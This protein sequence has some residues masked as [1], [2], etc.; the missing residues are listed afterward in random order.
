MGL[1]SSAGGLKRSM[2]TGAD[3]IGSQAGTVT[4][5]TA[6]T[7][8]I[9]A[10]S[11]TLPSVSA[12]TSTSSGG[13]EYFSAASSINTGSPIE[14][15]LSRR[16][17]PP[18]PLPL[19]LPS[20]V[21]ET[22][23]KLNQLDL[24]EKPLPSLPL[25]PPSLPSPTLQVAAT[26]SQLSAREPALVKRSPPISLSDL[27]AS[28]GSYVAGYLSHWM[29][30]FG[31]EWETVGRALFDVVDQEETSKLGP[32]AEEKDRAEEAFWRWAV[33]QRQQSGECS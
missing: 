1:G 12:S 8:P 2:S 14:A 24:D 32:D 17:G 22:S 5:K 26:K 3:T 33:E 28:V 27:H 7:T 9:A 16:R 23:A 21:D 29:Y 10:P 18:S 31:C 25:P 11:L 15:S 20:A 13:E 4:M 19:S 6:P 30:V